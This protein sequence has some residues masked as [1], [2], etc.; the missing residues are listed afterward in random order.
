MGCA[1][2]LVRVEGRGVCSAR[3]QLQRVLAGHASHWAE[4]GMDEGGDS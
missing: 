1:T 3:A 4:K 2:Y